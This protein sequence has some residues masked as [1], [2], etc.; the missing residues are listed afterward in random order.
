MGTVHHDNE[1]V[2]H[3]ETMTNSSSSIAVQSI[4]VLNIKFIRNM[5][6]IHNL[7]IHKC[8]KYLPR[9][10]TDA[11][12]TYH[13]SYNTVEKQQF[14]AADTDIITQSETQHLSLNISCNKLPTNFNFKEIN[15]VCRVSEL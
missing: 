2:I 3:S 7:Y 4:K 14:E 9:L 8:A 5:S 15:A 11:K 6:H 1:H 12:L 13:N 10:S